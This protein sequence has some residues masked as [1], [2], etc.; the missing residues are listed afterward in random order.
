MKFL[1]FSLLRLLSI[2][3]ANVGTLPLPTHTSPVS[4]AST[5]STIYIPNTPV[6]NSALEKS[7]QHSLTDETHFHGPTTEMK[8]ILKV[9]GEILLRHGEYVDAYKVYEELLHIQET[10]ESDD[11]AL[12][13]TLASI[14][15][16]KQAMGDFDGAFYAFSEILDLDDISDEDVADTLFAMGLVLLEGEHYNE[17]LEIMHDAVEAHNDLPP[18]IK[19]T[20]FI[21]ST[22]DYVG[23]IYIR[24]NRLDDAINTWMES[25]SLWREQSD[26]QHLADTL[27]SIGVAYF[28]N[29]EFSEAT[30][31][32]EEAISL[33]QRASSADQDQ[34]GLNLALNNY[35]LLKDSRILRDDGE[36]EM[37]CIASYFL[38]GKVN[39][40]GE[41]HC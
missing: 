12:A 20:V 7:L 25:S 28:R 38:N 36:N 15:H 5:H 29:G 2:I 4:S 8:E 37:T 24:L 26:N 41:Q 16:V 1:A 11:A 33:Y 6:L 32:Y 31:V 27:N 30:Q 34:E 18:E 23:E 10:D 13:V 40:S 22:L 3:N 35:N 19:D 21:A 9:M 39:K 17:A 14:G